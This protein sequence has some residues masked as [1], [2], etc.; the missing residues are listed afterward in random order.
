MVY[1]FQFL[2]DRNGAL[3]YKTLAHIHV[4]I[5]LLSLVGVYEIFIHLTD[6]HSL[7]LLRNSDTTYINA[8]LVKVQ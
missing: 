3:V 8:N 5:V 1:K 6:D 2:H 4:Y 7:V